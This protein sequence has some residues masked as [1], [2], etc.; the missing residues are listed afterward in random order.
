MTTDQ[1]S[2]SEFDD[3]APGYGQVVFTDR[4]F[5]FDGYASVLRTIVQQVAPQPGDAVLDLGIGTGNLALLFAELGCQIWGV[6]FSTEMLKFAQHKLPAATL[7]LGDLR[8][9]LPADFPR[10]FQ[11]IVS[12][13]TFHH[14]PL[15]EKVLLVQHLLTNHLTP[16]SALVIGDVAFSDPAAE[17]KYRH[18]LG[19]DWEQE[20]YWLADESLAAFAAA[21]ISATYTQV[22]ACAG[23]FML[24]MRQ[25]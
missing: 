14:F 15:D 12:A 22:S 8:E 3:W 16:D 5:P 17:E 24:G 11:R 2:P 23:V 19:S 9:E 6:D 25:E 4:G 10:R 20:Y 18:E 7:A 21:G 13:Y 1:F